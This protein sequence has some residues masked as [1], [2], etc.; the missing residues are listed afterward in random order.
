MTDAPESDALYLELVDR[1]A[2]GKPTPWRLDKRY[3][4]EG[5]P[6]ARYSG[7]DRQALLWEVY[8][9]AKEDR[10]LEQWAAAAIRSLMLR[11]FAG[12][13]EDWNDEFGTPLAKKSRQKGSGI[14]GVYGRGHRRWAST[15]VRLWR[16]GRELIAAGRK[17]DYDFY[18]DLGDEFDLHEDDVKK[19][20]WQPMQKFVKT[21]CREYL[22]TGG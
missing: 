12:R 16:R 6:E 4:T 21:Y 11:V 18:A 22:K 15:L 7:G 13:V 10:A 20:Y 19:Y 8:L 1:V 17:V 2:R 3:P 9:A 5:S 14:K